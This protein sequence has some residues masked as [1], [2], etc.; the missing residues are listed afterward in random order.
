VPDRTHTH[1]RGR[2]QRTPQRQASHEATGKA[3]RDS[4]SSTAP[5]LFA[6]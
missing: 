4:R 6:V 3:R 2:I 1:L 5:L